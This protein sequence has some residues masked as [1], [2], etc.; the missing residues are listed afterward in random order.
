MARLEVGS[1]ERRTSAP[2][3]AVI[4]GEMAMEDGVV[5]AGTMRVIQPKKVR[6]RCEERRLM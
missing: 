6:S 1:C 3:L 4:Q 5:V 2:Y